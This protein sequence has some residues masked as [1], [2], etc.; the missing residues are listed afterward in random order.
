MGELNLCDCLIYLDDI[1]VFSSTFEEHLEKLHAELSRL[2][3]NN[4]K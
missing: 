3:L 4:L 2:A 1:V